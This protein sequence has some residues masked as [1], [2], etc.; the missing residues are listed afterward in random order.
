MKNN[1]FG[2]LKYVAQI[3]YQHLRLKILIDHL[4]FWA[5]RTDDGHQCWRKKKN[6]NW[7]TISLI[8]LTYRGGHLRFFFQI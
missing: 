3:F 8:L 7:Y 6:F 2:E 4:T 1:K 5:G